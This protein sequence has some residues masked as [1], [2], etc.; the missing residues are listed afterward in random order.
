LVDLKSDQNLLSSRI[1]RVNLWQFFEKNFPTLKTASPFHGGF[2]LFHFITQLR[3][4]HSHQKRGWGKDETMKPESFSNR[5]LPEENSNSAAAF[6]W[7]KHHSSHN[8]TPRTRKKT[9]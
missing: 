5:F 4:F 9:P 2:A 1:S 8:L 3:R 6:R 7:L